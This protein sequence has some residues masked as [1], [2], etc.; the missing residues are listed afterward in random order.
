MGFLLEKCDFSA[1]P[2]NLNMHNFHSLWLTNHVFWL[3]INRVDVGDVNRQSNT[4]KP[5]YI[6]NQM[7]QTLCIL[8]FVEHWP[9]YYCLLNDKIKKW[10][11]DNKHKTRCSH[12]ENNVSFNTCHLGNYQINFDEILNVYSLEYA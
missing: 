3:C 7:S 4:C 9:F 2:N 1:E 10:F 11:W 6:F 8:F 5:S 12:K